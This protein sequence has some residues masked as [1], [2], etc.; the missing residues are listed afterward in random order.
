[1]TRS[2]YI[3]EFFSDIILLIFA[4][5]IFSLMGCRETTPKLRVENGTEDMIHTTPQS[6][7]NL[8]DKEE[9]KAIGQNVKVVTGQE[10]IAPDP[11]EKNTEPA[12]DKTGAVA[13]KVQ[14]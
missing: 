1:M 14:Y 11:K 3:F 5:I 10:A 13:V 4:L 6:A 9:V 12:K 2:R 8:N 7:K